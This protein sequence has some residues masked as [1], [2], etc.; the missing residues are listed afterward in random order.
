ME[1]LPS[2][3]SL[4]EDTWAAFKGS[5]LNVILLGVGSTLFSII[6]I[7]IFIVLA[8]A[9]GMIR[10]GST[11]NLNPN[12]LVLGSIIF[13][14]LFVLFLVIQ[15]VFRIGMILAIGEYEKKESVVL[16]FKRSFGLFIP[17]FLTEIIVSFLMFGAF[18][19]FIIPV[20]FFSIFLMFT[21]FEVIL[22]G[23]KYSQALKGSVEIVKQHFGDVFLR[24]L[25]W[26]GIYMLASM[27]TGIITGFL[28]NNLDVLGAM[29]SFILNIFLSWFGTIYFISLYKQVVKRTDFSGPV[30]L[31]W[32][33]I[34]SLL[35]WI[36]GLIFISSVIALVAANSKEIQKYL[37]TIGDKKAASEASLL[38]TAP[39][40]C[41]L[42]IPVPKT[43]DTTG[44]GKTR[45]WL[46]E[47]VPLDKSEF[48]ILNKDVFSPDLLLGSF[49]GYKESDSRLGGTENEFSTSY[50]GLIVFCVDNTKGLTLKEYEDLALANKDFK[51][52]TQ[53]P[54][55]W[56][57]VK[58][59]PVVVDG[60]F[61]GKELKDLGYLA[62]TQDGSRL[63]YGRLWAPEDKDPIK[64][65]L[66][67]DINTILNNLK[68]RKSPLK[69]SQMTFSNPNTVQKQS[70]AQQNVV[71]ACTQ[72]NI[73]EGEFASNKCYSQ[74]DYSDLNYYINQFNSAVFSYNGANGQMSVTCNGSDFFKE[75]CEVNKK[76]KEQAQADM[77]KY[78]GIINGIIA[79]GK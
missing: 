1:K 43:T 64:S 54:V 59:V 60:T 36:L 74:N 71:P 13:V 12:T 38:T 46:Y 78:R 79:R 47:E 25:V 57:E 10:P 58:F 18:F 15:S 72:Y 22:G 2:I 28:P 75:Q 8:F 7:G 27:V 41:G 3:K 11:P 63:I 76:E 53:K 32:F 31:K 37:E 26:V 55:M 49:I 68:Y 73:R 5:L 19:F 42:S 69:L 56:G 44:E 16:L 45:K 48:F 17:V 62:V 40:S 52:T 21:V 23:K 33:W 29:G 77:D 67:S 39:S 9:T 6:A 66:T 14:F 4:F 24:L 50:P 65:K 51:V 70:S 20:L 35:G 30:S 61:R 34:V